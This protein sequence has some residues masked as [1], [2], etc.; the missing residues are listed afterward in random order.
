MGMTWQE[1]KGM[2]TL[3]FAHFLPRAN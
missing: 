2:K 1:W 3:H